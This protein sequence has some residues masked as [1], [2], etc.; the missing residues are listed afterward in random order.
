MKPYKTEYGIQHCILGKK[1][2]YPAEKEEAEK[3][4]SDACSE[5]SFNI[6]TARGFRSKEIYTNTPYIICKY[7]YYETEKRKSFLDWL[8]GVFK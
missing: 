2:S 8:K 4:I 5:G 6:P 1:S 3:L 7:D